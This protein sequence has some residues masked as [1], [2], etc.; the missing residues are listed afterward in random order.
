MG[1]GKILYQDLPNAIA[2]I[3]QMGSINKVNSRGLSFKLVSDNW[4]TKYRL[5]TFNEKEP[6]M[7]DWVDGNL[8]DEDILFDVGANIGIYSIYAAL[9]KPKATVYAFEP[10]YSNLNQLKQNIINNSLHISY[11]R[12]SI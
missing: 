12:R 8:R 7:L 11:I 1:I 3:R 9:R 4:I 2:A 10:E 5:R 6:E